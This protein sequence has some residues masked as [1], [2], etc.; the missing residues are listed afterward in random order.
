MSCFNDWGGGGDVTKL[1]PFWEGT[2]LFDQPPGEMNW[3]RGK[4]ADQHAG[5]HVV[6]SQEGVVLVPSPGTESS[7]PLPP[8]SLK[9][10]YL[11]NKDIMIL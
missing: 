9:H 3:I 1:S 6:L 4:L 7:Y 2:A 5:D 10:Y 11:H 8:Q